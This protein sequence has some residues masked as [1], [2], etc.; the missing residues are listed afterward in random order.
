MSTDPKQPPTPPKTTPAREGDFAN[1]KNRSDV[2]IEK[3]PKDLPPKGDFDKG[4]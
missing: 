2:A 3:S 4:I 1:E